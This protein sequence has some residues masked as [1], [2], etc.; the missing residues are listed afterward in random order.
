MLSAN[1]ASLVI[2]YLSSLLSYKLRSLYLFRYRSVQSAATWCRDFRFVRKQ[3]NQEIANIISEWVMTVI[4]IKK[5]IFH[6]YK[7]VWNKKAM[8]L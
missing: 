4:Y 5:L 8:L 3:T 7:F 1:D 2:R 6:W